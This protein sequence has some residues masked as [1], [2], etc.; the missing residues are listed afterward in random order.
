MGETV[1][2]LPADSSL[3]HRRILHQL[4]LSQRAQE[5]TNPLLPKTLA[6][7]AK[8]ASR[9]MSTSPA[10]V[11]QLDSSPAGRPRTP[12]TTTRIEDNFRDIPREDGRVWYYGLEVPPQSIAAGWN[13]ERL[14]PIRPRPKKGCWGI[15]Q[16]DWDRFLP[17]KARVTV[18]LEV[19]LPQT[20]EVCVRRIGY[21]K[22]TAPIVCL[23]IV[24]PNSIRLRDAMLAITAVTQVLW[25]LELYDIAVEVAQ[26]AFAQPIDRSIAQ[27]GET[28]GG[29]ETRS[30]ETGTTAIGDQA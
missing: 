20:T 8:S 23:I 18:A 29:T 2:P 22:D 21:N 16:A 15:D 9:A 27:E 30:A 1:Q 5:Q 25:D 13:S 6:P 17:A 14:S 4:Y 28:G 11:S 3:L 19:M 7:S 26:P 24:R 10:S 12:A